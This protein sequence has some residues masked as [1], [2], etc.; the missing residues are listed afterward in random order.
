MMNLIF[1]LILAFCTSVFAAGSPSV[2]FN[3]G[4]VA[5]PQPASGIQPVPNNQEVDI[6][7]NQNANNQQDNVNQ[8]IDCSIYTNGINSRVS[9]TSDRS[10]LACDAV[11][12]NKNN[13]R[14]TVQTS[15]GTQP[16]RQCIC[17]TIQVSSGSEPLQQCSPSPTLGIFR[18]Q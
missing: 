2:A 5:N 14:C 10:I 8:R 16:L 12:D 1:I 17:T 6:Q 3:Q 9:S 15:S 7:G 11:K 18:S 13:K 4:V